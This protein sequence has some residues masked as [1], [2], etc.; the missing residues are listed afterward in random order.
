M[1][2]DELVVVVAVLVQVG[3]AAR[4][5]RALPAADRPVESGLVGLGV[6]PHQAPVLV[7][8]LRAVDPIVAVLLVAIVGR[9]VVFV[10]VRVLA[11]LIFLL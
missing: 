5:R 3:L 10:I 11:F 2:L 9:G 7:L 4:G 8:V 6:L 1:R